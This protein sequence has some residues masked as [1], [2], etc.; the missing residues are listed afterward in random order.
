MVP[1]EEEDVVEL[2][3]E[4][5]GTLGEAGAVPME[6]GTV[7]ERGSFP[8]ALPVGTTGAVELAGIE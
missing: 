7:G 5:V 4:V 6:E 2:L 1:G 3:A 8:G